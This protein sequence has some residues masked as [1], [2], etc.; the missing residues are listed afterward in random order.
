MIN[1]NGTD[2]TGSIAGR[3]IDCGDIR[4]SIGGVGM[5][6]IHIRRSGGVEM[7]CSPEACPVVA[8]RAGL[9][10]INVDETTMTVIIMSPLA[11]GPYVAGEDIPV[12]RCIMTGNA[13]A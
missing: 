13:T 11:V 2:V 5:K 12:R 8:T 9:T 10:G 1:C 4:N 6:K 7:C 3:V